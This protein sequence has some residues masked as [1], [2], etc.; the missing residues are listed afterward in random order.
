M[1]DITITNPF[2]AIRKDTFQQF[3]DE[4][5]EF[6][7]VSPKSVS[8]YKSVM[9]VFFK[10]LSDYFISCPNYENILQWRELLINQHKSPSTVN[11]YLTV[12]K[13]FFK[14]L[15]FKHIYTCEGIDYIKGIPESD[16]HKKDFLTPEQ[17]KA[18]VDFFPINTYEGLRDKLICLFMLSCGLRC[19]EI[20]RANLEDLQFVGSRHALFVQGKGRHDKSE[21]VMIPEKLEPLLDIYLKIRPPRCEALFISKRGRI[22]PMTISHI[23]KKALRSIGVNTPRLTA[24]SLRHTAATSMLL[25][26]IDIQQVQQ[27]LRHKNINTTM[28]YNHQI[29]RMKNKGEDAAFDYFSN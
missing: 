17:A 16:L 21:C 29:E 9:R 18:L 19:I 8:A 26:G 3:F 27:I 20:S 23:I 28:I 22:N 15:D 2:P 10:Y 12:V 24:H 11:N 14:F 6:I 13:T 5:V 1:S 7:Q 4:W 25:A